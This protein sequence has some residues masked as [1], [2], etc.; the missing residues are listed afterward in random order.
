MQISAVSAV[1][2]PWSRTA[3]ETRVAGVKA[4]RGKSVRQENARAGFLEQLFHIKCHKR[5]VFNHQPQA[6]EQPPLTF[7]ITYSQGWTTLRGSSGSKPGLRASATARS[8]STA[9]LQGRFTGKVTS[10]AWC[11]VV[12]SDAD[13]GPCLPAAET[14]STGRAVRSN[15]R[16]IEDGRTD[17]DTQTDGHRVLHGCHRGL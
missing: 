17:S 15:C 11:H 14:C 5:F 12:D 8:R 13:A 2:S 3:A 1:F 9:S 4:S 6:S 10:V 7:L 16:L